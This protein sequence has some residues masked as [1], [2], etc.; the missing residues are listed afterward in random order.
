MRVLAHEQEVAGQLISSPAGDS[1]RFVEVPADMAP[2]AADPAQAEPGWL[3][4]LMNFARGES[5]A[6]R[7]G[8]GRLHAAREEC[9]VVLH[10]AGATADLEDA[11]A[12]LEWLCKPVLL[13]VNRPAGPE[14]DP[15]GLVARAERHA[16]AFPLVARVLPF[17]TFARSW[18]QEGVL[19]DAI[20]RTLPEALGPGFDRIAAAWHARNGARFARSMQAVAEHL[21]FA[22]RQVEELPGGALSVKS[23]V[24]AG[25][26]QA[27]ALAR[28][29]AVQA[30]VARLDR[31]AA[32]MFATLRDL[33]GIDD[34]MAD[35]L[36]EGLEQK[37][38]VRQPIDAPQAA[39]AGAAG[40]AATGASVDLLAGGLTLG[41]ATA[42]GALVGASA[43]IVGAA[44]KNRST[45]GGATLVQLSDEMMQA[46]VEAGLLRY[47]AAA[48][49]GRAALEAGSEIRPFWK[50]E[51]VAAV[52][53]HNPSLA[54]F[55]VAAR[56]QPDAEQ[57]A[58]LARE[59]E[60]IATRV[61]DTLYPKPL[62]TL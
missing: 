60:I 28:Q 52:E 25:E 36:E 58:A 48:H 16:R 8:D 59:L 32:D 15:P 24:V 12:S 49:H 6:A 30:V 54:P 29:G 50:A 41:A 47:L 4:R 44:L 40:G 2:P 7:S 45:S 26:R 13:L 61:L 9:H 35:E 38:L 17:D 22:A 51:V 42:L 23:L 43:A 39:M 14:A 20:R 53:A 57:A 34:S 62:P 37:F 27:Q 3:Q 46:L 55:W 21:L 1:L 11:R 19:L 33:H 5:A 18:V 56:S 31:S 10:V